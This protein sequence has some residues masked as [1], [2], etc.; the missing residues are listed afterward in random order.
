MALQKKLPFLLFSAFL[1]LGTLLTVIGKTS[2]YSEI[3][4]V[5]FEAPRSLSGWISPDHR[6]RAP[7]FNFLDLEGAEHSL[8]EF[9]GDSPLLLVFWKTDCPA[10]LL[11]FPKLEK[12]EAQWKGRGVRFLALGEDP[13]LRALKRYSDTHERSC[14]I[15]WDRD[16]VAA[17]VYGVK[18]VPFVVVLDSRGRKAYEGF[19]LP[20]SLENVFEG[21]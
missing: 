10:C 6:E 18:G 7:S 3:S 19:E 9:R 21:A 2:R 20:R 4:F 5:G 17:F 15:G 12:L 1:L 14:A 11:E 8:E 13:S 16:G